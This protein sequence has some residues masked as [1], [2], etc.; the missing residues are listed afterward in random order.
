M[1][2]RKK[3][4]G[5]HILIAVLGGVLC[6]IFLLVIVLQIGLVVSDGIEC[7]RPDYAKA[8][9]TE[10]LH[11]ET[12]TDEDYELLYR[13]TGL[14]KIGVDRAL[15]RGEEGIERICEIQD[16]F[17]AEHEAENDKFGPWA[18]RDLIGSS[19]PNIYLED[20]DIVV[21]SST[22]IS[23]MRIGHSGL[24][25]D[26]EAGEVL[27]ANTYGETSGMVKISYFTRRVNFMV[28][29]PKADKETRTAA[30]EYAKLNL[31]DLPYSAFVGI[32]SD[33]NSIEKTQCAHIIWYAYRQY[34]LELDGNGGLLVLPYDI[35]HSDNVELVQVFGLDPDVLW[36]K[37]F[38]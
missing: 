37:L 16:S 30:A 20:G 5:V 8:D 21:T 31:T 26:G 12:L 1:E 7:W 28:F 32:F 18:C 2:R 29:R 38:Y 22:H 17:F 13:Q 15:A 3:R 10:T 33:K 35:A 36:D 14:T 19:V 27:Q 34:G 23:F 6:V 9:L 11:K 4:K 25:V 24:V